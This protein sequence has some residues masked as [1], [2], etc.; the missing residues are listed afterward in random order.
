MRLLLMNKNHTVCIHA[1]LKAET[2]YQYQEEPF[3]YDN[4]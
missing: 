1:R 3:F 4:K 2:L